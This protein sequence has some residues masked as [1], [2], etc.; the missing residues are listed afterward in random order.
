MHMEDL[1]VRFQPYFAGDSLFEEVL[2]HG[3]QLVL[4][5]GLTDLSNS[6]GRH[7]F[8]MFEIFPYSRYQVQERATYYEE[9]LVDAMFPFL[10]SRMRGGGARLC[11]RLSVR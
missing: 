7:D 3:H 1:G 4:H 9:L 5:N 8:K 2:A 11:G 6:L 10:L